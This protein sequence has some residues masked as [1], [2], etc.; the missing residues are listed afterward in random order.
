MLDRTVDLISYTVISLEPILEV[1]EAAPGSG[2]ACGS[3]FLNRIFADTLNTRFK[4]DSV[5]E[6]D[7][8]ILD[9]AMEYFERVTKD[10]FNGKRGS[11]IPM[12]GLGPRPDIKKRRLELSSTEIEEIFEPV[13][14]EILNLIGEQIRQ[15]AKQVKLIL[16]VGGFGKSIYLQDR[17]QEKFGRWIEVKVSPDTSVPASDT[18]EGGSG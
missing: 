17:I 16:L 5:W 3:T 13:I 11:N 7:P 6:S 9:T 8:D 2:D 18:I 14:S 12:A 4:G 15:T 1:E 10:E